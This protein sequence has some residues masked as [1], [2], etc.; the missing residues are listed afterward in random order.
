MQYSSPRTKLYSALFNKQIVPININIY[1][2]V[3]YGYYDVLIDIAE[4][5][6]DMDYYINIIIMMPDVISNKVTFSSS[7]DKN[8]DI[9]FD[10]FYSN[11]KYLNKM[12]D[13]GKIKTDMSL[14]FILQKVDNINSLK[15]IW[16]CEYNK[17][18]MFYTKMIDYNNS[19]NWGI[20]I[21]TL[22]RHHPTYNFIKLFFELD[23]VAHWKLF[24]RYNIENI[25][26]N[27]IISNEFRKI[28]PIIVK[29]IKHN[30]DLLITPICIKDLEN[31]IRIIYYDKNIIHFYNLLILLEKINMIHITYFELNLSKLYYKILINYGH[32]NINMIQYN[33][34]YRFSYY[35]Y[36]KDSLFI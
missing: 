17:D 1:D 12:Y 22:F 31:V 35:M 30:S 26:Y 9:D 19:N 25:V 20:S 4:T 36:I 29:Y 27:C 32:I 16:E 7:S 15:Y 13:L 8:Y 10:V 33:P 5:T 28:L 24:V 21:T 2:F 23:M 6:N 3:K 18:N 11:S 14:Y 34:Y